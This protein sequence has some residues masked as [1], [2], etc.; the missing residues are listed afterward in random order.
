MP[1]ILIVFSSGSMSPKRRSASPSRVSRPVVPVDLDGAHHAAAFDAEGGE[2]GVAAGHALDLAL[3]TS[4]V[5]ATVAFRRL[6]RDRDD[7]RTELADGLGLVERDERI[8]RFRSASSSLKI[9]GMRWTVIVGADVADDRVR[10]HPVH[11]LDEGDHRDDRGDRH[12]V[13][14]HRH[15]RSQL[16]GPDGLQRDQDGVEDLVHLL[17]VGRLRFRLFCC[18]LTSPPSESSRTELN[19]PVMT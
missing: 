16:V 2:V 10:H 13:A 6:C 9:G 4:S 5:G 8:V 19:G 7:Q 12:D 11:A 3:L 17:V 14:Q 1:A 18:T 15:E